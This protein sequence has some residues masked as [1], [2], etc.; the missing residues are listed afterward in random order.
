MS[1]QFWGSSDAELLLASRSSAMRAEIETT[2][3]GTELVVFQS[4][5][6][7]GV[8]RFVCHTRR[9]LLASA[10]AVNEHLEI[11]SRDRWFLPL[12]VHHVGGFAV[13]ARAYHSGSVVYKLSG[14]W[15]APLFIAQCGVA[16]AAFTSLVPTQI[17]DLVEAESQCPPSLRAVLVGGGRLDP[18]VEDRARDLGWP[19]LKTYGL[20]E[21]GSQ[22]ATQRPGTDVLVVLPHLEAAVDGGGRLR[23]RGSSIAESYLTHE[24]SDGW[25]FQPCTDADGWLQTDDFV[26]LDDRKL[27]FLGRGSST[28]K[29]LGELVNVESL[30]TAFLRAANDRR[31]ALIDVPDPRSENALV[32]ACE[33]GVCRVSLGAA[34]DAFNSTVAGFERIARVVELEDGIPRGDLGKVRRGELRKRVVEAE[35]YG[36]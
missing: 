27:R 4:S 10:Q 18:R 8:P 31:L 1:E 14:E 2:L 28:V 9:G 7:T 23:L 35:K 19:V 22:V 13:C 34:V 21:A 12:P 15:S 32:L 17:F 33:T 30:E 29:I 36:F 16:K 5:G 24:E 26:E 11:S 20:T 25:R 3:Q 6:T